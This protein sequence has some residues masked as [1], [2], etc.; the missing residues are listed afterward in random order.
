MHTVCM[1]GVDAALAASQRERL[2][3]NLRVWK[4]RHTRRT[5]DAKARRRRRLYGLR[6][7][8]A[9]KLARIPTPRAED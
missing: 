5:E 6:A 7:R 9:A 3:E 2:A 8:H 1:D 4:A